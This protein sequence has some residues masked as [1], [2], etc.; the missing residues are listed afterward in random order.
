LEQVITTHVS[1]WPH[2]ATDEHGSAAFSI[3]GNLAA[4]GR[5]RTRMPGCVAERENLALPT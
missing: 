1:P 2:W 5:S 3:V 4:Y